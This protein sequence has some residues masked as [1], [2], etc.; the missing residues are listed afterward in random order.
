MNLMSSHLP[1]LQGEGRSWSTTQSSACVW[2]AL[3]T[4]V[5]SSWRS[6]TWTLSISS[7]SG[8]GRAC[9][10]VLHRPDVCQ[11]SRAELSTP[12]PASSQMC[13]LQDYCGT[14]TAADSSAEKHRRCCPPTDAVWFSQITANMQSGDQSRRG[15]SARTDSVSLYKK[16]KRKW[17]FELECLVFSLTAVTWSSFW[18]E[19]R[20]SPF[21]CI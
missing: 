1:L 3:K 8:S 10:C 16:G 14:V 2:R 12:S 20:S 7:G 13:I 15:T 11:P 19:G 5:K 6:A 17:V 18:Q 4:Q 21:V 9:W